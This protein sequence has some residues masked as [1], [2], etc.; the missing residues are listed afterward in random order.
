[1]SITEDQLKTLPENPDKSVA[2]PGKDFLLQVNAGTDA[3][4]NFIDVG[5]QRNAPLDETAQTIDATHK[6]SGGWGQ[7]IAGTRSW[8]CSYQGLRIIND[9]GLRVLEYCFHNAKQANVRFVRADGYYQEGWC[10]VTKLTKDTAYNGVATCNMTL[11]GVGAISEETAPST[12][13][14]TGA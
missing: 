9:D 8:S 5:G 10:F 4:A 7:T 13:T 6:K 12:S 1:M 11:S 2:S 3:K 14:G